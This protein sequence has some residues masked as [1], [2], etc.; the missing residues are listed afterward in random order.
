[1]TTASL[2]KLKSIVYKINELN[3]TISKDQNHIYDLFLEISNIYSSDFFRT[4][5]IPELLIIKGIL[6]IR[7]NG[8]ILDID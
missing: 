7:L 6:V 3:E 4:D 5:I 2:Q 8:E 1:M